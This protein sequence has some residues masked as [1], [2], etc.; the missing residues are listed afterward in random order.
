MRFVTLVVV[1]LVLGSLPLAAQD[2][3]PPAWSVRTRGVMTGN[4]AESDPAGFQMYSAI[5]LEAALTR[6]LGGLLSWELAVRTESREVDYQPGTDPAYRQGSLEL[7]PVSLLL[8]VRPRMSGR[9][10]AYA[11]GGLTFTTTWEKSGVLD[12]MDVAS[13]LGPA[14]QLGLDYDLSAAVLFNLDLRWNG[15]TTKIENGGVPYTSLKVDPIT[16]GL[17]VGFRF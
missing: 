9:F 13:H 2:N 6:R 1:G 10:H 7:L 15:L 8:Q 5:T 17:G 12:S 3:V 11:G 16:I 14:I 4:S